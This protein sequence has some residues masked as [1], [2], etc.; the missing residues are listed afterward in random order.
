MPLCPELISFF[1]SSILIRSCCRWWIAGLVL[2]RNDRGWIVP[3]L[4]WLFVTIRIITLYVPISLVMGP[5]KTVWKHTVVRV[6]D[7]IPAKLRK[8]LAAAGTVAAMLVGAMVSEESA[9]NTRANRAVS[10]FGLAVMIAVLY[11]TSRNRSKVS[12]ERDRCELVKVR[13]NTIWYIDTMAYRHWGY[14]YPI[15][16]RSLCAPLNGRIRHL[17]IHFKPGS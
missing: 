3:F 10:L 7:L 14:A 2:H 17:R 6:H 15:R 9:D 5:V 16:H 4:V 8:P 13:A 12:R 11:A 1:S